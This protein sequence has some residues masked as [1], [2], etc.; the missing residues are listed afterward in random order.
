MRGVAFALAAAFAFAGTAVAQPADRHEGYYYP[1]PA[2]HEIYVSRAK[3]LIDA[4]RDRRLEFVNGLVGAQMAAPYPAVYSIFAKGTQ[5]DRL[6]IVAL[7]GGRLDTAYR[8]RALLAQLTALARNS[9]FLKEYGVDN[10]F[11]FLD[12][13][14]LLGFSRVTVSDGEHFA[15][16]IDLR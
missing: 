15:H 7:E 11:T 4:S 12:V 2:S 1:K 9:P 3:V 6:I 10:L 16:Q 5:A 14:R 13:L 8:A